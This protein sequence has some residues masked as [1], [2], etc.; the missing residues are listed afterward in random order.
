MMII[1]TAKTRGK[2]AAIKRA[3]FQPWLTARTSDA[4]KKQE[5]TMVENR[6]KHSQNSQLIN[7]CPT[8]EAVSEVSE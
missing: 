2:R 5:R 6:K 3:N 8:S 1:L 7:H 4:E